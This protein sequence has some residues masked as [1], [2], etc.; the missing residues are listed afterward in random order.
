MALTRAWQEAYPND[1]NIGYELDDYQRQIR[2]DVRERAAVQHQAYLDET[3]ETDVWEHTPG[4]CTIAFIGA[5]ASFP[6][7]ATTTSGCLAVATDEA[8]Q[9]YYWSGSAWTKVQEPVLIAGD[10][11]IAD[12]KTFAHLKVSQDQDIGSYNLEAK[13]LESNVVSGTPPL[14]VASDTKVDNLNADKVDGYHVGTYS[15][16]QSYTFPGG[17]IMKMGYTARSGQDTTITFA[18][19]FPTEFVSVSIVTKHSTLVATETAV[20]NE[21]TSGFVLQNNEAVAGYYWVAIGR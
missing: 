18:A 3:G 19:A 17:L 12:T 6:V 10:Q 13:T 11:T 1:N 7:P 15:G 8:N 14:T 2:Q 5:K 21:G 20:K 4:E 9:L 16:E